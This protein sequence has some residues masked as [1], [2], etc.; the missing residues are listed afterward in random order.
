MAAGGGLSVILAGLWLA[1]RRSRA[2]AAQAGQAAAAEAAAARA[3]MAVR[4]EAE[5]EAA[6]VPDV[7]LTGADPDGRPISLRVPGR[8]V[9]DPAGAV[10]GRSPFEGEVVLN[11]PEVSRRH[12]RLFRADGTLM[13]EDLG[14]MNGTALDGAPL[15]AGAAAPLTAAARLRIGQIEFTV[16]TPAGSGGEGDAQ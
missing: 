12:F 9:A 15:A 4:A 13:V 16:R 11:H 7:V 14:S 8:A 2:R 1:A 6:A 10:V 5:R 3:A